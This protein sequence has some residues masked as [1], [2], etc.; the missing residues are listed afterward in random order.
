MLTGII[1]EFDPF[2]RGHAHLLQ[3]VK[4]RFPDTAIAVAMSGHFTQRGGAAALRPHARAEMALACGADLVLELPLPWAISSAEAFALGGASLLHALG[5]NRLAFGS[6]CADAVRLRAAADCL[7]SPAYPDTLRQ[8]LSAGVPF[9]TAR[10]QAVS[11]LAGDAV[12]AVLSTPNDLLGVSYLAALD[13]LHSS[14][15]VCAIPRVGVQHNATVTQQGFSSASHLRALLHAGDLPQALSLLPDSSRPILQ[16][17][18]DAGLAPASLT[19]CERAVLY[20]LRQMREA[21]FLQLPDCSEG[22]EHRLYRAAQTATS[23]E[24]FYAQVKTKRY[25][26]ARI[27]RLTLW[28]FLGLTKADRPALPPYLRVLAMSPAGIRVLHGVKKNCPLPIVTKPAAVRTLPE[29]ARQLFEREA[30]AADIWRLCLP[31]LQHS[32]AGSLW[33]ES[34]L[35]QQLH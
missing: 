13:Q 17:E 12:G 28:A 18:W 20:R 5:A 26:H 4:R 14:A 11:R 2:H 16:R 22:L 21:D 9:A 23:L 6:E 25:A 15:E 27:R 10:Q 7:Q 31:T 1:A 30:F 3:E 33:R 32:A 8:A 29:T 34:A 35:V 19:H 24:D